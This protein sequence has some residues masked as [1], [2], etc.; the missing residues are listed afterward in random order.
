[1]EREIKERRK[2]QRVPARILIKYGNAEQF[3]TDYIQNISRGGIFVPTYTP[4]PPGTHLKISFSLPG[5]D[6]LIET[7]GTVV[8]SVHGDPQQ[9]GQPSG[10]GVQFQKLSEESLEQIDNYVGTLQE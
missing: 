7:E 5:W 6:R 10:M 2:H 8:H 9:G 3:F 1:M 4:L